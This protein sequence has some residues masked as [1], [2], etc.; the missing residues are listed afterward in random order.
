MPESNKLEYLK[1]EAISPYLVTHVS[2]AT[3]DNNIKL[4]IL[5]NA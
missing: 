4:P 3:D 5:N 1:M 2:A